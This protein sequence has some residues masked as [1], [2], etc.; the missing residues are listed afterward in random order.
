MQ[1]EL[2]SPPPLLIGWLEFL[3]EISPKLKSAL[4][5]LAIWQDSGSEESKLRGGNHWKMQAA[6]LISVSPATPLRVT[7]TGSVAIT[8]D[9]VCKLCIGNIFVSLMFA[10]FSVSVL[11]LY[12]AVQFLFA[13]GSNFSI[14]IFRIED[15]WAEY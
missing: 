4:C 2:L 7:W 1:N 3:N 13:I 11:F 8:H 6:D 14:V 10:C 9:I 12:L 5:P 15:R